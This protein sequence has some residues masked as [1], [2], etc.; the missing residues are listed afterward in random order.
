VE[1]LVGSD[2]LA[3]RVRTHTAGH[4]PAAPHAV[5]LECASV[6]RGLVRGKKL[7]EDEAARALDLLGRMQLHRYEH[8]PLLP[9]IWEL[10]HN[11][12]PYDASS[13]ALAEMLGA[14]LVTVDRKFAGAPGIRCTVTGLRDA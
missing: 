4:R 6:L 10:R 8:T 5:D 14:E 3:E 11:M 1:F 2:V 12:G 13:I 9:R 7:P